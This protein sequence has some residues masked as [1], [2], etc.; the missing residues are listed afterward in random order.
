MLFASHEL[1]RARTIAHRVVEIRGGTCVVAQDSS[2]QSL[3]AS[4]GEA[5]L[6]V[7]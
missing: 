3:A 5:G 1:E 6:D 2:S 7:A 4:N